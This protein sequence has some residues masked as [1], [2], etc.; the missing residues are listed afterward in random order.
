LIQINLLGNQLSELRGVVGRRRKPDDGRRPV[1]C[2]LET[3]CRTPPRYSNAGGSWEIP[4]ELTAQTVGRIF[5]PGHGPIAQGE[6]QYSVIKALGCG[7][8]CCKNASLPL[9]IAV[10]S[11][12][13]AGA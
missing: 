13:A 1:S 10:D 12:R 5:D 9:S 3:P 2:K 11:R 7:Q 8:G 4:V 6:R